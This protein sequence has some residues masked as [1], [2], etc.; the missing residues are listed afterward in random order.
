MKIVANNLGFMVVMGWSLVVTGGYLE[1]YWSGPAKEMQ[2]ACGQFRGAAGVWQRGG[3]SPRA[4]TSTSRWPLLVSELT[5]PAFS[6]SSSRRAE[7]L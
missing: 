7:R 4:G 6:I 3:Y 5:S 1:R 2:P